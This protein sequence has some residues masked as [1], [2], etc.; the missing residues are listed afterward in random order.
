MDFFRHSDTSLSRSNIV[1]IPFSRK[2]GTFYPTLKRNIRSLPAVEDISTCSYPMYMNYDISV[3]PPQNGRPIIPLPGLRVDANFIAVLGIRWKIPP[4]DSTYPRHPGYAVLNEAAVEKLGLTGNPI[5]QVVN[6]QFTV[7]GIVTNFDYASLRNKIDAIVLTFN[8]DEDT[9]SGWAKDGGCLFV[10]IKVAANIPTLIG[11]I[12]TIYS[13]YDANAPFEYY[14]MDDVFNSMYSAEDKLSRIFTAFTLFTVVV[15]CIGLLGMS[16][17]AASRRTKEFS[18]RKVLGAS[19]AGIAAKLS[20]DI[21]KPV[22]IAVAVASP[23]G[24]YCMHRWLQGFAYRVH[25]E[26]WILLMA[27]IIIG[28]IALLTVSFQV[29][30]AA[31]I[32]PAHSLRSD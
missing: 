12:K 31:T 5:N 4:M 23:I 17:F 2:A 10:K 32:N 3:I 14:F 15:A 13:T 28:L 9:A 8:K 11:R 26:W 25:F 19:V 30:K 29:I 6:G 16:I 21:L 27:A 1:M 22:L 24:W 7:A 20:L 18:I